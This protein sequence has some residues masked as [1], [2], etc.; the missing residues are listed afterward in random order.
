MSGLLLGV[1][2]SN[3]T[4]TQ[5]GQHRQQSVV[6][7]QMWQ[8]TWGHLQKWHE[9]ISLSS[10]LY[11]VKLYQRLG[12]DPDTGKLNLSMTIKIYSIQYAIVLFCSVLCILP[13]LGGFLWFIN[14][15]FFRVLSLAV[16]PSYE[17]SNR[18]NQ[19][20]NMEDLG[21]IHWYL[22]TTKHNKAWAV[23][24]F[25]GMYCALDTWLSYYENLWHI[26]VHCIMLTRR[27]LTTHRCICKRGH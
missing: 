18:P 6:F 7:F 27:D 1:I 9:I 14:Q 11:S 13:V 4:F 8:G 12:S 21:K 15:I 10:L 16:G 25:L 17:C 22:T 3:I 23:H 24:I 2:L 19:W 26:S 5:V 20:S